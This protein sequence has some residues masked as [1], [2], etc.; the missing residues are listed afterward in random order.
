MGQILVAR[1]EADE[2]TTF[3][4]DVIADRAAQD[5]VGAL[6]RVEHGPQRHRAADV[7]RHFA[8][9][10]RERAQMR[11]QLHTDAHGSV[12]ASTDSTAGRC[13]AIGFQVSPASAD[14]YT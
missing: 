8:A 4:R 1:E 9:D 7:D 13:S 6:E 12:W 14:A 11:W 10:A 2:R 3:V 5:G